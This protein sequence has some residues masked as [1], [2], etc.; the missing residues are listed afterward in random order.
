MNLCFEFPNKKKVC[1][2]LTL[3]GIIVQNRGIFQENIQQTVMSLICSDSSL[4]F[5]TFVLT[6]YEL[7]LSFTLYIQIRS[8]FVNI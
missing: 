6:L 5:F 8:I 4:M 1:L 3:M 2:S 7:A